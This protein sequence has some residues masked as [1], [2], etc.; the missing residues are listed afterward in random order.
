MPTEV[1]IVQNV[2]V[3]DLISFIRRKGRLHQKLVLDGLEEELGA[4]TPGYSRMRKLV[5][6]NTNDYMRSIV[7]AIFGDDFEGTL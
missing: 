3:I 6:D 2:E 4:G 7:K 1:S 5:L